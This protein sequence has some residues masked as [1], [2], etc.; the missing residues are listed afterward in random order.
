[1]GQFRL[2]LRWKL[3]RYGSRQSRAEFF[4]AI[5]REK[6]EVE[7]SGYYHWYDEPKMTRITIHSS[8][9][10][11]SI[12]REVK[13]SG[14]TSIS[15]FFREKGLKRG[16]R[17]LYKRWIDKK[18]KAVTVGVLGRFCEQLN[19]SLNEIERR[20]V[21][22][23]PHFYPINMRS[24]GFV[25]MR[26]HILDEGTN[27]SKNRLKY[28]NQDPV[29]LKYFADAV[30]EA[31][32]IIITKP[33]LRPGAMEI[34]A[35]SAL[36]RAL[37]ASGLPGGRKT[38]SNPSLDPMVEKDPKSKRY[39]IQAALT[40]EGWHSLGV[41]KRRA[42][43]EIAW[44]RAVDITDELSS[45]QIEQLRKTEKEHGR[46]IPIRSIEDPEILR[47]IKEKPPRPLH[48]ELALLETSHPE[49]E[50]PEEHPTRVHVSTGHRVTSFWEI[51]TLRSDLI[52]IIHDEYG[53]L[54][55]TWKAERFERL[56]EVY[57]K[58]RGR[59]LTDEEIQDI[60]KIKE[61]NPP[62]ISAA[63]VSEKTQKLFPGTEWAEDIERIKRMLQRK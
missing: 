37:E 19:I 40:E 50:W 42:R 29:L 10:R 13:R 45:E 49:K 56:Y 9:V 33:R 2:A 28:S 36:G 30:R 23:E 43:F 18:E 6:K 46:K 57:T 17:V 34:E 27:S 53:M 44:G 20:G 5:R 3:S 24:R 8:Y 26:T 51:H 47:I 63:W 12:E 31:G 41:H 38:I 11:Q 4:E 21:I 16:D 7:S 22:S 62:D 25:K 58:Y 52:D 39:H 61:E 55:G 59:K 15:D 54:P 48:Q 60:R 35:N 14:A 1:L 32:G